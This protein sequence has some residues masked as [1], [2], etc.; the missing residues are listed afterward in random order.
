M[1]SSDSQPNAAR[2]SE[3]KANDDDS[4]LENSRLCPAAFSAIAAARLVAF[5][6]VT[7]FDFAAATTASKE[8]GTMT[9]AA[10]P[11][12]N[13]V[14]GRRLVELLGIQVKGNEGH[15]LK[16]A[17]VSCPSS[18]AG[19]LHSETGVF[20]CYS[21]GASLS[22]F[23][24]CEEVMNNREDAKKI[25][26]EVGLFDDRPQANGKPLLETIANLKGVSSDDFRAFGAKTE[27]TAIVFP[28]YGPDGEQCSTFR[29]T[30]GNGKGLYEKGKPV[31]IF[32]P[33]RKPQ[34]GEQWTVVEGVKDAAALHGMG[35]LAAGLP[36][37]RLNAKFAPLFQD[38]DAVF[39]PDGDR[40]GVEGATVSAKTLQGVAR[41]VRIASLPVEIKDTKG[42]DVRD[43]L[44]EQGPDV[45]RKAIEA[46][47]PFLDNTK[48]ITPEFP[49]NNGVSVMVM[50]FDPALLPEA[51]RLWVVDIA[52][53]TQC[54]LDFP[55]VGAMV[56]IA[57]LV[58]RQVGIRP[59]REDDWEVI[60]NLWGA[61]IGRPG[62]MKSPP[63]REIMKPLQRLEIE[64]S[65]DFQESENEY[66]K[67]ELAWKAKFK[68]AEDSLLQAA[69]KGSDL[70]SIVMP[71][72]PLMTMRRRFITNDSTVPK[73]GEILAGSPHGVLQYRD[74]LM[75]FLRNLDKPG[76]EADRA[77][78]IESWSGD[79]R[80]TFDRIGRGT[81]DI[82]ACCISILATTQP[83]PLESYLFGAKQGGGG[84][85]GLIQRFQLM[86]YPE[87]DRTWRNVDR[88]PNKE[89]REAAYGA[90]TRLA[91]IDLWEVN[92][93]QDD[94]GGVPF[95]RFDAEAQ[96]RFDAWRAELEREVRSGEL[97]PSLESHIAK[98]RSLIPSL[99]L[100]IH[101]ADG[102]SGPVG[103]TALDKATAWG[104]YLRSHAEKIYGAVETDALET[105]S[106]AKLE[107][108][109]RSKGGRVTVREARNRFRGD[110]EAAEAKLQGWAKQG[111][112]QWEAVSPGP[113][114]GRPATY[115]VLSNGDN[116]NHNL[117]IFEEN[118]VSVMAIAK[119]R[120]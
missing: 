5:G 108:F 46:A 32:L 76:S 37:N 68:A 8:G 74:E 44:R 52:E 67:I 69:K 29:L 61:V 62:I 75:G 21:C 119:E 41:S 10:L 84:D 13:G 35:F 12:D 80:F 71:G 79:G 117:E 93:Q 27:G 81:L 94:Y 6:K 98:Y 85:D 3:R 43:V 64:Y 63:I 72:K 45:I 106:D 15:D 17:C 118:E 4:T 23:A 107:S 39:I 60:P 56:I 86:V 14:A 38:A 65:K 20:H 53:R 70:Q 114:G 31:G 112:G 58:G 49:V 33:G 50:P 24:L 87:I 34:A 59:K 92:A 54:P 110:S 116:H 22:A 95:L 83:G 104:V 73:L 101:L 78:Y 48:T 47:R 42:Q 113:Y 91:N 100:L 102:R 57:S 96:G 36:N 109:I 115:F 120:A 30:L 111:K 99:A 88:W 16:M 90:I 26:V 66:K 77:F 2:T 9:T 1:N 28:M 18:D 105:A 11:S 51:V 25:M 55:A 89:A 40:P 97:S 7:R 82:P 19:R 103:L